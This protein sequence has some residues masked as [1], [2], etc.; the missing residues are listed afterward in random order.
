M[1]CTTVCTAA[2]AQIA[3]R[4]RWLVL[5]MVKPT[6]TERSSQK[7]RN[8]DIELTASE[9]GALKAEVCGVRSHVHGLRYLRCGG[10]ETDKEPTDRG[11]VT[12]ILSAA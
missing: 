8:T 6:K 1:V 5:D 3:D 4:L 12:E 2:S 9:I 10:T 11:A 7:P